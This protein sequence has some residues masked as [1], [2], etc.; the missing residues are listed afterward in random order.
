MKLSIPHG[1]PERL[2]WC[3]AFILGAI[4]PIL[5]D[6]LEIRAERAFFVSSPDRSGAVETC[7]WIA[8][9]VILV[10]LALL[11]LL[12]VAVSRVRSAKGLYALRL[13][14]WAIVFLAFA[15]GLCVAA[16]FIPARI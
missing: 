10:G 15:L 6:R 7:S 12:V 3:V 11:S 5:G 9:V 14:Q 1:P 4:S 2:L 8:P 16:L 13:K